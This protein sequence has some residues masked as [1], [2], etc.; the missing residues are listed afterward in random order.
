MPSWFTA[1]KLQEIRRTH[2]RPVLQH[3]KK[4]GVMV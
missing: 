3:G 2:E 4:E 1:F